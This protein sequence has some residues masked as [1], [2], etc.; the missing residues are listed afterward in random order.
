[1]SFFHAMNTSASGLTAQRMRMDVIAQNIANATTTMT[2]EGGPYR[3]KTVIMDAVPMQRFDD[4]LDT[5]LATNPLTQ[6]RQGFDRFETVHDIVTRY[7]HPHGERPPSGV[8]I[9][10]IRTD[11]TPGPLVYDPT[12]PHANAQGYVEM[13]N[14]NIVYEMVNM[15]SA[16]RSYEANMTALSTTRS[17][18]TSTLQIAQAT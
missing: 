3:R 17:M 12:H 16:S 6:G 14:V 4:V 8:Q 15:M 1:M 7:Q 11:H 5:A 18:I 9:T 13:P 10:A 2:P